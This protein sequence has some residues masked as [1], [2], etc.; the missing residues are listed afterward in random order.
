MTVEA[1]ILSVP[2]SPAQ[3]GVVVQ[4]PDAAWGV[5]QK[6]G[7]G[8]AFMVLRETGD[9]ADD[10]PDGAVVYRVDRYGNIG[11]SG[12]V[13][14][15]TGLRDMMPGTSQAV[16]IDPSQDVVPLFI[17]NPLPSESPSTRDFVVVYDQR[18]SSTPFRIH[19]NGTLLG[20]KEVVAR[21]G[22]SQRTVVGAVYGL[23]G[24]G[25]GSSADATIWRAGPEVVGIGNS[26]FLKKRTSSPAPN[27]GGA[28]VGCRDSGGKAELVATM[29]SGKIV[30]LAIDT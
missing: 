8:Q 19:N 25:M 4:A 3:N 9:P 14:V 6:Y 23:A 29:P 13:H 7:S 10:G 21:D 22:Q 26:A 2:A 1:D 24:L 30:S 12:G 18:D 5:D 15:A 11:T 28:V 27:A 20:R 16:W 17:N